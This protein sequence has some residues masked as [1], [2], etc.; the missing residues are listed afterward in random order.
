[1]RAARILAALAI[2]LVSVTCQAEPWALWQAYCQ[3]FI[4]GHGRVVDHQGGDRTTSEGQAYALFF[5]LVAND[6]TQFDAL[7]AWTRDNLAQGDLTAHPPGWQWGRAQD[8][9][10]K[11]LDTN[12]ASDADLWMS[13]TLAEAGRLWNEPS[14]TALSRIMAARIAQQEVT[15]LPGFGPMLLPGTNGFHPSAQVW[16]L[17]PSYVPLPVLERL[18]RTDATGPWATI[19]KKLPQFLEQ[20][21]PHGFAMDWVSYSPESGFQPVAAPGNA[22]A[23][24]EG[25]YD[26]IRVYLWAG[27]TNSADPQYHAVMGAAGGMGEWLKAHLFPP[28][29]VSSGGVPGG[30]DGPVGFSAAT[31]PYLSGLGENAALAK[32]R[33]RLAAQLDPG[34]KLYGH[35]P[36]YYDQNLA[37]FSEGWLSHRFRFGSDGELKVTWKK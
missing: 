35:P 11:L 2:A 17:N 29:Q 26:A 16:V 28:V 25:S 27:M 18:A 13:Y 23:V 32:Q 22:K 7:L 19:A 21:A 15:D 33:D 4:D 20:S 30:A 12:S 14:Y 37:M 24:P 8:G 6:R 31:V 34:T 9:S 10:W 5:A 1:M 3:S 36:A